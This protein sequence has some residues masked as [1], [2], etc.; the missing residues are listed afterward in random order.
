MKKQNRVVTLAALAIGL[1]AGCAD[2]DVTNENNPDRDKSLVEPDALEGLIAGSFRTFYNTF[3]RNGSSNSI[4]VGMHTLVATALGEEFT[5][6]NYTDGRCNPTVELAIEPRQAINNDPVTCAHDWQELTFEEMYKVLS[7]ANDVLKAVKDRKI[8]IVID[9]V[10]YTARDVAFS[11]FWQGM[12]LGVLGAM[13]DR[14]WIVDETTP[15][16][17]IDDPRGRIE[18]SA[19]PAVLTAAVARLEEAATL[20][21]AA[22]AFTIPGAWMLSTMDMDNAGLARLARSMA[23]RFMVIGARTP[24]ERAAV[25]WQK[26]IQLVDGGLTADYTFNMASPLGS[27][28]TYLA[29]AIASSGAP[30]SYAD[31]NLIGESDVSGQY[32]AW[33]AKPA[34]QREKF[35]IT[36]PDRRITGASGPTAQ[37]AYFIYRATDPFDR[38]FGSYHGSFYQWRRITATNTGNWP[39]ISLTELNLYKAEAL[40][41]TG[42]GAGAAALANL[43]RK[44]IG[45]LP[46]LTAAG[47]PDALNCVPRTAA[48]NCGTLLDA[49]RYERQIELAG[50]FG[51]YMWMDRRG[52][53]TLP[54]GTPL[55]LPIPGEQLE[56]LGIDRY[57]FGG[58]LPGSAQ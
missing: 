11:K 26:V 52:W 27:S 16:E 7:N 4:S 6:T 39:T 53:G 49:I 56:I 40:A 50:T 5:T 28:N 17:A 48:G 25:N 1:L 37:G 9:G 46:D 57:S 42:N 10:D 41:R 32:Q 34:N 31:I 22:P 3:Y 43:R 23:A 44:A 14:A 30:R 58:G 38:A 54:K 51:D 19:H 21:L 2:L 18:L 47:V 13:F 8:A 55:H 36:T 35:P 20:A 24:A 29:Y 33:Y 45:Q 12:G 15:Q